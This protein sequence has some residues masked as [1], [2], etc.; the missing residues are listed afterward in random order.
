MGRFGVGFNYKGGFT[1]FPGVFPTINADNLDARPV[2]PLGIAAVL[3]EG[4]GFFEPGKVASLPIQFGAPRRYLSASTLLT[5]AEL[6]TK[7]FSQL[8]RGVGQVLVV[9]VNQSTPSTKTLQSSAPTTL[10]TITSKGWGLK[11]N[12][13]LLKHE[14]GKL[15]VKLPTGGATPIVETFTYSTVQGLVNDINERSAIVKATFT[16]NGTV[17]NFSETAMTGGTEPAATSDDWAAALTELAGG[18]VTAVH[19]ATSDTSVWAMLADFCIQKRCRGFVGGALQ[20]WNGVSAR[21]TA[22]AAL[23]SQAAAL[24]AVRMMHV[25]LGANGLPGY[26]FAARY[27]A[28]AAAL[29]PSVPMT[30]KHLDVE[31]LEA[32]LDIATEVGGVDGLLLAGV[33][34][35][36][37]DPDAL[38]TFIVSR[39]LSTWI[40]DDNLYRREHSVLAASDAVQNLLEAK[41]R[42]FLGGEGTKATA[43]RAVGAIHQ[44]LEDCTKPTS[45]VR[46]NGYRPESITATITDTVMQCSAAFT[47]IPPVNFIPLA[48]NL[49]R[50]DIT[51]QFEA[52]LVG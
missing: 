41:L 30:F 51:V 40:G 1:A 5:C 24:N 46:I 31:S 12:E 19:V 48:L 43:Q 13:I 42:Q 32:R 17:V 4:A 26:Q 35:P 52:P 18:N 7:P 49:E 3:A 37:P 22:I 16:A 9:P 39:G 6:A 11:F 8:D 2:S 36:V 28:L 15:T 50:T 10:A 27:A 47:P 23:K 44:T 45:V 38:S 21:A 20:S 29:E 34:P 33:A 14:T 25:G